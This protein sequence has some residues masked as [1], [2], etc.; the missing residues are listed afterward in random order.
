MRFLMKTSRFSE[1]QILE[2]PRQTEGGVR[3]P[4]LRCEHGMSNASFYIYGL[5]PL[6]KLDVK[7]V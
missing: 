7:A 1:P 5:F 3:V 2:I 4:E 6:C